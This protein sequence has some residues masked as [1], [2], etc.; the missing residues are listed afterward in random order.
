MP[1]SLGRVLVVDDD[2]VIRKLISVNLELE[3]FEVH[4]ASDGRNCL[5]VI[6]EV[7]PDAVTLDMLM[8]RMDGLKTVGRLRGNT[9]T[10]GVK[11][12]MITARTAD[13]DR[14]RAYQAGVDIFLTKPFDPADL[15]E[16]IRSV[17]DL[18]S[19]Q[20]G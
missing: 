1:E 9:D 13:A 16:A 18:P 19:T 11:I 10:A 2:E 12:V 7:R 17:L 4:T 6:D 15:V 5:E 20:P 3:G 8:P 14:R